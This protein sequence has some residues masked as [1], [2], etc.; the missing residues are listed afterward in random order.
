MR[1]YFNTAS[2]PVRAILEIDCE[3]PS[4]IRL[5]GLSGISKGCYF[6]RYPI[7]L[8]QGLN[9]VEIPLPLSPQKLMVEGS[10]LE[11]SG[12]IK[13]VKKHLERLPQQRLTPG[14]KDFLNLAAKLSSNAR[15][16]PKKLYRS[17]SGRIRLRYMSDIVEEGEVLE[18]PARVE[19]ATG[20]IEVSKKRFSQYSVGMRMFILCHEFAHFLNQSVDEY[21]ADRKGAE[22]YLK[23]GFPKSEAYYSL[24]D[25]LPND[26]MGMARMEALHSILSI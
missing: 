3:S 23:A 8:K 25:I 7:M 15:Q 11:G 16:L 5:V 6:D 19:I 21:D 10:R 2:K 17:K 13:V 1:L 14:E 24:T 26:P 18:T 9:R 12:K 22:L 20:Y 4:Q